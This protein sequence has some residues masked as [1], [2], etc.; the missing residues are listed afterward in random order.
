MLIQAKISRMISKDLIATVI[1]KLKN[2][3][4][5]PAKEK[6]LIANQIIDNIIDNVIEY[7]SKYHSTNSSIS[8]KKE[9][10]KSSIFGGKQSKPL[11]LSDFIEQHK[12]D[13]I[14]TLNFKSSITSKEYPCYHIKVHQQFVGNLCG[15]HALF[16]VREVL[17]LLKSQDL[18]HPINLHNP[19]RYIFKYISC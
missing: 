9:N 2:D 15:Y 1:D 17:K 10:R 16:S 5:I 3:N 7:Y 13:V 18:N 4:V 11:F 12:I 14:R 6:I 8:Y 19:V